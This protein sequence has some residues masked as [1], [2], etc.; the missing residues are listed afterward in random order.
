[1]FT[2]EARGTSSITNSLL[3]DMHVV[4]HWCCP[5]AFISFAKSSF[6]HSGARDVRMTVARLTQKRHLKLL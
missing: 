2:V 1:M 5:Q 6:N 4:H 3:T